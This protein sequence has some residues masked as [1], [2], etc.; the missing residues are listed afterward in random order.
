MIHHATACISVVAA[1]AALACTPDGS[2]AGDPSGLETGTGESTGDASSTGS[3]GEDASDTGPDP[4]QDPP[5]CGDGVIE[6]DEQCDDGRFNG[7]GQH[8]NDACLDNVCGDADVGPGE[9]CDDGNDIDDDDCTNA[10][11]LPTCGNGYLDPGEECEDG[12][13]DPTDAC[14]NACLLATCGDGIVW[15]GFE[16]CDDG[17]AVDDDGCTNACTLPCGDGV[18]QPPETCDD[19]ND[20]ANDGCDACEAKLVHAVAV[21]YQHACAILDDGVVRCWGDNE[22]GQLGYGHTTN[23]GNFQTPAEAGDVSLA[24]FA[25]QITAGL[26]H[27]CALLDT[28]AVRCW[29]INEFGQLG[30]GH[31]QPIGDDEL[32]SEVPEVDVGGPVTQVSAAGNR[33][34][35]LLESKAVRCWGARG[36]YGYANLG[37]VG[38]VNPP[39]AAGDIQLGGLASQ[40]AVGYEHACALLES[41]ELRCWGRGNLGALGYGNTSDVGGHP[42]NLPAAAGPVFVSEPVAQLVAGWNHTCVIHDDQDVRCWGSGGYG[43]LGVPGVGTIGNDETPGSVAPVDVGGPV[44]AI[45]GGNRHTCAVLESGALRCWGRANYG[46]LGYANT[47][48]IGDN[49]HPATAG[50]VDVGGPVSAIAAGW[51]TT[52]AI[53]QAGGLRC[54]GNDYAGILGFGNDLGAIGDDEVPADAPYVQLY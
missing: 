54:W 6:G 24:G 13:D 37:N 31:T 47:T 53:M 9:A 19:G 33:T 49:E 45:A 43:V 29:G 52:C 7:P 14:T 51:E 8:C 42:D 18:V 11:T 22:Y 46:Q 12:N 20:I 23:V 10:C 21:G 15:A 27:T 17:N 32:P 2:T 28:G 26:R 40:I 3:E 5:V 1:L 38:S 48:T 30:L 39:S 4:D 16:E 35:A 44:T 50:D 34:C 25:V 36:A 41:G